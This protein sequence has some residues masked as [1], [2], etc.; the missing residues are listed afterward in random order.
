M[1]L[2]MARQVRLALVY[3]ELAVNRERGQ[4]VKG[5]S[6]VAAKESA[7]FT[8][9]MHTVLPDSSWYNSA[10]AYFFCII[11]MVLVDGAA[12]LPALL[13][14]VAAKGRHTIVVT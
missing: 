3:K 11:G 6:I 10:R 14:V 8:M 12:Q 9:A 5:S 4:P 7:E 2:G 13:S 1:S